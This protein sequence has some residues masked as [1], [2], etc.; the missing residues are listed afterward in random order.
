M[1][2]CKPDSVGRPTAPLLRDAELRLWGE[3]EDAL[4]A[5]RERAD[6]IDQAS[7]EAFAQESA[8]GYAKG[9]AGGAEEA[10]RIVTAA[11]AAADALLHRLE[12]ELP[13]IVCD[14]VEDMLGAMP[15]TELV[16]SAV[17]HALG[18]VRLG[19]AA[20]LRTAPGSLGALRAALDAPGG[21][22]VRLEAD[23]A[24]EDGRCVLSGEFGAIELDVAAQLRV[25][26]ST[27]LPVAEAQP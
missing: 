16:T 3:A 5:A 1:A 24:L 23:P 19:A 6:Q 10:A 9:R 22:L 26:R 11:A 7:R 12:A 8:R 13:G 20:T 2:A 25:L 21:E 4:R 18:R 14:I 17:R 27:L 15:A